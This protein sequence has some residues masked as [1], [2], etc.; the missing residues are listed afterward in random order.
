MRLIAILFSALAV[1]LAST[2]MAEPADIAA[3]SRSVVRVV[4]ISQYNNDVRLQGHGS[5]VAVGPNLVLT[6]AHVVE[7]AEEF[8]AVRVG[9]VP[10]EGKHGWFAR[11]VAIDHRRDLALIRL[12]ESGS[13]PTATLFTGPVTDGE[14]VFAAGYPGNVDLAQGLNALDIVSPTSPVKTH[15]NVSNGRSSKAFQT[16]LHTAP[17]GAGNSGG[18]LF[19]SCGR[20]L[21]VNS[22]GTEAASGADSE[23]YF[24]VS[25]PEITRFLL[26]AGVHVQ[27]TGIA[28]RSIAD[29][30]RAE[31]ERLAGTRA[32]SEE[33]LRAAAE[34]HAADLEKARLQAQVDVI[35]S[36]DNYMALAGVALLL[37]IGMTGATVTLRQRGRRGQA[38]VAAVF[39]GVF[40]IGTISAWFARPG[41][42]EIEERAQ[43]LIAPSPSASASGSGGTAVTDVAGNYLCVLQPERSRVT[44]SPVTDVPLSWTA[45]GCVNG[46]T[47]YGLSPNG[48]SRTLVPKEEQ[49]ATVTNF[50]PATGTY[51]TERYMLDLDTMQKLRAE[52]AKL[53]AP[54]CGEGEEAARQLGQSEMALKALLPAEPNERMVYQ[55]S[56][57][58]AAK[59]GA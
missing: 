7:S 5:G 28:C 4:L 2:A 53:T 42:S 51:R 36:R 27:S 17:I 14:D 39:A 49:T 55:C 15:G 20:V 31:A 3:A 40:L 58:A 22:F 18:P 13:L 19:D 6:N 16:I 48:W 35:S 45:D 32:Q 21:G 25:M 11:I 26:Q 41:V 43:K 30:D 24:A 23:F 54:S 8:D 47:P 34:K 10:P 56:K 52:R 57:Q 59:P 12:T 33:Q 29:L 1:L 37:A 50:D 38:N 44:V 9:V 46:R